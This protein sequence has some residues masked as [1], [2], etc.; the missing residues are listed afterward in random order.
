MRNSLLRNDALDDPRDAQ[1]ALVLAL[2][3]EVSDRLTV[4]EHRDV[5]DVDRS[6]WMTVKVAAHASG[7][8][9]S[10]VRKLIRQNRV[11]HEWIGGR[12]F[13]TELPTRKINRS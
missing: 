9:E 5:E 3:R 1:M 10:A 6:G 12:V 4:L 8:S 13:V 11:A 7:Y 2:L